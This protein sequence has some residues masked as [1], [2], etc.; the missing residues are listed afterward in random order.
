[1]TIKGK[2]KK[3][4]YQKGNWGSL[5][6]KDTNGDTVRASGKVLACKEGDL[7]EMEG[8]Y[9][10]KPPYGMQFIITSSSIQKDLSLEGIKKFLI[11]FISGVG[12][13]TADSIIKMFGTETYNIIKNEPLKLSRIKGISESK[14]LKMQETYLE[15]NAYVEIMN[16]FNG[17]ITENQALKIYQKYKADSMKVLKQNPYQLIYDI[18][19][20][21]FKKVDKLALASGLAKDSRKRIGAAIIYTLKVLSDNGDLFVKDDEL[22]IKVK[23][24]LNKECLD[25]KIIINRLADEIME[26]VNEEKLVCEQADNGSINIYLKYLYD[27]ET[28]A[29]EIIR[30]MIKKGRNIDCSDAIADFEKAEDI[31]FDDIQKKAISMAVGNSFSTITGGPGMGKTTIIKAIIYADKRLNKST[32]ICLAPT[33]KAAKRMSESTG[34]KAS[35]IDSFL[36]KNERNNEL[37]PDTLFII[38]ETSMIDMCKAFKLLSEIHDAGARVVFVGDVFQLPSIGPGN[39]LRDLIACPM[40][41]TTTLKYSYRFGGTI[42]KD[43]KLVNEGYNFSD[44]EFDENAEFIKSPKEYVMENIEK[45]FKEE[46][47]KYDIKDILILAP[48]K[49]RSQSS[50]QEIN[51]RIRDMVNPTP[52]HAKKDFDFRVGDRVMNTVNNY[53]I[54]GTDLNNGEKT[55]GIFNGDMGVITKVDTSLSKVEVTFDDN[56][57]FEFDK[58]HARSLTLSYAMTYHK[59]Q[60]SEAKCVIVVINNEHLIMLNRNLFYTGIT[61]AKEKL[62][63]IGDVYAINTAI[64]NTAPI[65]RNTLL[66]QRI[67]SAA[68]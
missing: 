42:A 13:K 58:I 15:N 64:R 12:E 10:D 24:V 44:L 17:D 33:G 39:F 32:P 62:K 36:I 68:D 16:Y 3:V 50:T 65:T 20:M 9:E 1:M 26:Q 48:M 43:A 4:Y 22:E 57:H 45:A 18:D 2:I 38:D 59:A 23:D 31:E 56:R 25:E 8:N 29:A 37:Q 66:S 60:G 40:V 30:K 47:R 51:N 6:I 21:G 11:S 63:I 53:S 67:M 14:A 61:R 52:Y 34:Y 7:I 54:D 49:T 41:P 5:S 46:S 35:T 28:K 55:S 27:A 19:G